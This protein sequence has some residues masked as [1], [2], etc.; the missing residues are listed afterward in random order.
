MPDTWNRSTATGKAS[1]DGAVPDWAR[2]T[3]AGERLLNA[4]SE[5]FYQQGIHAV[6]V[7]T[8][9]ESA[10]TT[11]K[12]LY[13]RFGSKDSLVAMYLQ[14]RA[15]RWKRFVEDH[16]NG[17]GTETGE[18]EAAGDARRVAGEDPPDGAVERVL[19]VLEALEVWSAHHSRGC[20]FVNAYAEIGGT[21]HPG[22]AII[23]DE[24]EW[25]R[26]LYARLLRE[27]GLDDTT[28]QAI[29]VQLSLL[30]EGT[31]VVMTAGDQP[32]VF[33]HARVAARQL[34]A[35]ATLPMIMNTYAFHMAGKS[36]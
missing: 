25:T 23:R 26:A 15:E 7:D 29:G 17:Q 2:L 11:K 19:K 16:L 5:L 28:A 14:R 32:D 10:G 30:H 21:G 9:A 31:V 1:G 36:S 8:I 34:I 4:A 13:D 27:A 18:G 33:E 22:L 12:T 6:G 3:P 35:A 24:K 20:A